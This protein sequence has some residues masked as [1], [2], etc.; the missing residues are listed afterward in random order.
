MNRK[1]IGVVTALVLATVGTFLIIAYVRGIE[2]RAMADERMVPV[3]VVKRAI[4]EGTAAAGI[5]ASVETERVPA[6]VRAEG[7]VEKLGDLEGLVAAVDLVPGEQLTKARFL[8]PQAVAQQQGVQ[9][10]P[11]LLEVTIALEP[12]RVVGGQIL[13]GDTVAVLG[14]FGDGAAGGE[15][16]GESAIATT[17]VLLH[18]V[19]VTDLRTETGVIAPPSD[20]EGEAEGPGIPG[21]QIFVTLALDAPSVERVVHTA[22]FG[23]LWLA[24]EPEDAPEGGTR[25]Q[26]AATIYDRTE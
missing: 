12:S 20:E 10:P 24:N 19:L 2:G 16:E 6:K 1:L 26:R 5:A 15:D 17:H 18:K 7:A 8:S 4:A 11:G 13:P 21:T 25:V 14:S 22:E 9:I 23:T 3:L